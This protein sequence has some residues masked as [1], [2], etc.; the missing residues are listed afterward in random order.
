MS[1]IA[2]CLRKAGKALSADDAS[3]IRDIYDDYTKG[4]MPGPEA[5]D[6]ALTD[7]IDIL[8]IERQEI[9]TEAA[10]QGAS[11]ASTD[12]KYSLGQK[13]ES[14]AQKL[15]VISEIY[16]AGKGKLM[17]GMSKKSTI[18]DFAVLLSNRA[19]KLNRGKALSAKTARNK[20]I[21]SD[22]IALEVQEALKQ[23]GHAGNWYSDTLDDALAIAS[24][25]HP[26]LATDPQARTAFLVGMA[27]T[28]NGMDVAS[29]T[30]YAEH[31][32]AKYK[33]T[34][35]FPIFGKG[36]EAGAMKKA[37]EQFNVLKEKWGMNSLERFLNTEF[38]VKDLEILGLSVSGENKETKVFGSAIFGPKV[39]QA[40]FQNLSGNYSPLT[41]DRWWMR[42]WGRM[43]GNLAPE[44]LSD[45]GKQ[46]DAFRDALGE[47]ADGMAD[48]D[49]AAL[50][51]DIHRVYAKNGF[52]PRTTLNKAAK[53][54]DVRVRFPI[55]SPRTGAERNWIREV[56]AEAQQKLAAKGVNMNSASMQALLWYPEKDLYIQNG[57]SNAKAKPTDYKKEFQ[58][59]AEARGISRGDIERAVTSGRAGRAAD[60]VAAERKDPGE[61]FGR[62]AFGQDERR[63]I[64][65]DAAL[66]SIR[67]LETIY[68]SRAPKGAAK[69]LDGAPVLVHHKH[70]VVSA[71]KLVSAGLAAPEFSELVPSEVGAKLFRRKLEAARKQH[72]SPTVGPRTANELETMRLFLSP[73]GL[74]GFAIDGDSIVAMFKHPRA[75]DQHGVAYSALL[76][77]TSQGGRTLKVMDLYAPH[78]YAKVGFTTAA[79]ISWKQG[80]APAGV[81]GEPDFLYMVYD[82]TNTEPY[83]GEGLK[84]S[85]A[86]KAQEL[87]DATRDALEPLASKRP[88][89]R[90]EDESD[91]PMSQM[92][93]LSRVISEQGSNPAS[94]GSVVSWVKSKMHGK[95]AV[96]VERALALIPRRNLVDFVRG[97]KMSATSDYVRLANRMDG[98][99][100]ELM[101]KA[102]E[103][104]KHWSK[105]TSKNKAGGRLLG[106]LMHSA[107][108]LGLDPSK[109]YTSLKKA[110]N[111]SDQDKVTD[112]KRRKDHEML[113]RYWAKLDSEGQSIFNTVRDSYKDQRSTVENALEARINASEADPS[114]KQ[115]VLTELRKQFE[116]GRVAGPYFP[117]AR[118]GELWG[119]AR[120]EAG[121]IVA[122]S[123]FE[124]VKER[125]EWAAA[126]RE[127][128]Y[129]VETG[130]QMDS[131]GVVE[132]LDPKFVAK[133]TALAKDIDTDLADE[134]WQL[135]LRNMPEMSMRKAFMHRKGRLGFSNN[136]IRAFGNAMFHGSHQISKLEYSHILEGKLDEMKEQVRAMEKADDKDE[137]WGNAVLREMTL[138][139]KF[140]MNPTHSALTAKLTALGFAWYLGATPAAA[141]VNLSQTAI[142]AFP[143]LAA[144]FS[145]A[146]AGLELNKAAGLWAGTR[147]S[148]ENRLRG[149]ERAAMDEARKVG[150]FSKTQGHD[151]AGLSEGAQDYNSLRTK[152]MTT[153]SWMFHK[154]EQ[155]NR[156]I[157]FLAAYRLGKKKGLSH[158]DA[159][160]KAE[161]LVWDSHFD[162]NST[163]RPR[164][165]QGNVARVILLFRQYSLNMTYRLARDF[166]ESFFVSSLPKEERSKA[167]QRLAGMMM[168][169]G[170]F[171]GLVGQPMMWAVEY[172]LNSLLGDDDE[173]FD[174]KTA[175]RLWLIEQYGYEAAEAI[176]K[177]PT[178]TYIGATM[179]S[180]VSLS[181][182]W[183]REAPGNMEFGPKM[184]DHYLGEAVGPV[185]A[186]PKDMLMGAGELAQGQGFR[187]MERFV[188]KVIKDSMK[189]YRYLREGVT[190]KRGD[191]ILGQEEMTDK[192]IFFQAIGFT[193]ANL[194]RRYEE[195]RATSEMARGI[196]D[197]RTALVDGLFMAWRLGD[198][199][200]A[201]EKQ[202]AILKYNI[203]NP[204][205]RID[206]SNIISSA[207]S[208][209]KY[210]E[211]AVHGVVVNEG[212]SHLHRQNRFSPQGENE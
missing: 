27:V 191:V 122:F 173:P 167:K 113:Q 175:L 38:T 131:K 59:L 86:E 203:A 130:K 185:L 53:T 161:D 181:H 196:E 3:A 186:I 121:E 76:L 50:A 109:K 93:K 188:P 58:A 174:S 117:L 18:A 106:E 20:D 128:G 15:T 88:R 116:A 193:P 136:A 44:G 90:L 57:V 182:L 47:K 26:E 164:L 89:Y 137:L 95:N 10:T 171:A 12:F 108:L 52:Q 194:T 177:G 110:K 165:L 166:R 146:G 64:V 48:K 210:S 197:R 123:K 7:Y 98:R 138:R 54:L 92:G 29:N 85:T 155:A 63:H 148:I 178:D 140:A 97:D 71:N 172:V 16:G 179:S 78:L 160:V 132:R 81:K 34:G 150:V 51:K 125:Q 83:S 100:N 74:S 152:A 2:T 49:L 169:T 70:S 41:M 176:M 202:A 204:G 69:K 158:E 120:D 133:V 180:R 33:K 19:K 68:N 66:R 80:P 129:A 60:R 55:I 36:A 163:N 6:K 39:G 126:L 31:V 5:A 127:S 209:A 103:L 101:E 28:S 84:V 112:I 201:K 135:Y 205:R 24:I 96:N 11:P 184:Y 21:I 73:D 13:A 145:W 65:Q 143:V 37:F 159:I 22:T 111:M 75:K 67:Q 42:T 107:T 104:G 149:D 170:M 190:N 115:S 56:V 168:M 212:L 45:A 9:V 87:Q 23:T 35:K 25:V 91:T 82:R 200:T 99:A 114:V 154:A 206:V 119:A 162:Y 8:D 30:K 79:R 147:G 156:E 62:P 139:H 118:F 94:S 195:T 192:D 183:F 124:T 46:L 199:K 208:R 142:V 198:I 1:S 134:I 144:E 141:L 157:T 207:K 43:V 105:Y 151:L 211:R 14:F 61:A 77:A 4:G 187:A 102:D 17:E 153:I 32:Y 189:A 72:K 40:F